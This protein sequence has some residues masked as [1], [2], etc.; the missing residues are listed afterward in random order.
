MP[1]VSE[2]WHSPNLQMVKERKRKEKKQQVNPALWM[3]GVRA[4]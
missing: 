1:A 3:A 4:H 2:G